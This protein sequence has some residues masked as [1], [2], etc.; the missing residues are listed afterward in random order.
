MIKGFR[1]SASCGISR[2]DIGTY[3]IFFVCDDGFDWT[4][5]DFALTTGA[6]EP[7][8]ENIAKVEAGTEGEIRCWN[9]NC[10]LSKKC[11]KRPIDASA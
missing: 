2:P 3:M 10:R 4:L 1:N 11:T 7:T 5:N 6:V 9:C 8:P